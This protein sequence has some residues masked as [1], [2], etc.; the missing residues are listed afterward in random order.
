VRSRTRPGSSPP[1][2]LT[3]LTLGC[4]NAVEQAALQEKGKGSQGRRSERAASELGGRDDGASRWR[5]SGWRSS[6]SIEEHRQR[7]Q[8]KESERKC[9]DKAASALSSPFPAL[10]CTG[11]VRCL[12]RASTCVPSAA[13]AAHLA[14]LL[15]VPSETAAAAGVAAGGRRVAGETEGG[16]QSSG[17][18]GC[19][20][21]SC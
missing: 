15:G 4:G 7:T 18:S 5:A 13:V 3:A 8:S 12:S 19:C 10:D 21:S 16:H 2:L 17:T 9:S 1:L 20:S 6:C 14:P 11:C